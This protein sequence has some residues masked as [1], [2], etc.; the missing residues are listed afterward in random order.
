MRIDPAPSEPRLI[1]P[2]PLAAAIAAPPLEP[3]QVFA[4]FHGLRLMP[5]SGLSVTP[6]QPNSGMLVLP[7]KIAPCSRMR[8]TA[9]E[10]S[11]HGPAGSDTSEPLKVDQ[12]LLSHWSLI[13]VGTPSSRPCGAPLIQR[14]SESRAAASASSAATKRKALRAPSRC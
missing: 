11:L 6:F 4:G 8:A 1:A 5:V 2:M 10:S 14:I 9:G 7:R 3:P 13:V 12:P